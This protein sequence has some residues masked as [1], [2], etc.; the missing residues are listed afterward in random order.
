MGTEQQSRI[1]TKY[2]SRTSESKLKIPFIEKQNGNLSINSMRKDDDP[3]QVRGAYRVA[4]S[5]YNKALFAL[6]MLFENKENNV[7]G[8]QEKASELI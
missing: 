6:K 7:I 1:I 5:F 8:S 3:E 4:I 2:P